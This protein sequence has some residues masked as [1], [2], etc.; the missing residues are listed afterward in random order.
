M[1]LSRYPRVVMLTM[2]GLIGLV[3]TAPLLLTDAPFVGNGTDIVSSKHPKLAFLQSRLAQGDFPLWDPSILGG[4]P[5]AAGVAG[6]LTPSIAP[7]L[8]FDVLLGLKVTLVLHVTLAA[9]GAA[10]WM[11]RRT[12]GLLPPL[13]AA[14]VFALSGFMASHLYA[15]HL[16][17]V[18]A[19]AHLPWLLGA[20]E[21]AI[22]KAPRGVGTAGIVCGLMLLTGHYA[23]NYIALWGVGVYLTLGVLSVSEPGHRLR[24]LVRSTSVLA[25][26]VAI[27]MGLSMVLFLPGTETV[28]LSQRPESSLEF[29]ASYASS[30]ANL[31]SLFWPW[32][33]GDRVDAPFFGNWSFHEAFPYLGVTTIMLVS[34]SPLVL[35]VR[36]ASPALLT[37]AFGLAMSLALSTPLFEWFLAMSPAASSF[38]SPGRWVLLAV[39][40]AAALSAL[41][42]SRWQSGE[43]EMRRLRWPALVVVVASWGSVAWFSTITPSEFG[44]LM[45]GIASRRIAANPDAT[46]VANLELARRAVSRTALL[47][48]GAGGALM[49]GELF[50]RRALAAWALLTL[51]VVDVGGVTRHLLVTGS[52]EA[53]EWSPQLTAFV[54]RHRQPGSRVIVDRRLHTSARLAPSGISEVG[55]YSS[56]ASRN[57]MAL[58]NEARGEP[59]E[60][61]LAYGAV[62]QW[63]PLIATLGVT[64]LLTP[65]KQPERPGPRALS[66]FDD[67]KLRGKFGNV[68]VYENPAPFPR[69]FLTHAVE[70]VAEAQVLGRL[71]APSFDPRSAALISSPLPAP[72]DAAISGARGYRSDRAKLTRH[73][74][75][76]VE[77]E[78]STTNAALL[79]LSDNWHPGW[80]AEVDGIAAPV[81]RVNQFM[82]AVPVP[83]GTHEVRLRFFPSRLVPGMAISLGTFVL[84]VG[85]GLWIRR[86]SPLPAARDSE[87]AVA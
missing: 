43:F 13:C 50:R 69:A 64:Y 18:A 15:G 27:G 55:G 39:I 6:H 44:E 41:V 17:M 86:R 49:L 71:S 63:S 48:T 53:F 20:T 58:L 29:N 2:A 28:G 23:I 40:G 9:V 30:P 76:Q 45:N 85:F 70:L 21:R 72:F 84:V 16:R 62:R 8:L 79:V 81:A 19:V 56:T 75:D 82:R 80:S 4:V 65:V 11:S 77:L 68:Y 3:V 24:G 14:A 12:H 87:R 42:L 83:P 32:L 54:E 46:W 47:A 60:R 36:R 57:Y 10:W 25:A 38:R 22:D 1:I 74:P 26:V 61:P 33:Y 7:Q 67:W 51:V 5:F 31:F 66:G 52:L 37:M 35:G 73:E 59:Q 78:V 34:A